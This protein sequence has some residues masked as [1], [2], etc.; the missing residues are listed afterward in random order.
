M[1]EAGAE[2]ASGG[3]NSLAGNINVALGRGDLPTAT[4]THAAS[5]RVA[6]VTGILGGA[7]FNCSTPVLFELLMETVYGWGDEGMGGPTPARSS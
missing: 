2:V 1:A 6:Y 3:G 4:L 5:V 7:C